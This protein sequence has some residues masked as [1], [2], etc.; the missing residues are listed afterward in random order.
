MKLLR[1]F[2]GTGAVFFPVDP[3]IAPRSE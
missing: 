3:Y 2:T 1:P